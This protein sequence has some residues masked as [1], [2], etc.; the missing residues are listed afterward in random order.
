[1]TGDFPAGQSV[2]FLCPSMEGVNSPSS[3]EDHLVHLWEGCQG[4]FESRPSDA[5]REEGIPHRPVDHV[6]AS[7]SLLDSGN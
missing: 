3:C 2:L 7:L 6:R 1:M 5:G 4:A